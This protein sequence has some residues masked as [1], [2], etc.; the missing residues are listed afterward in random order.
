MTE[1][2]SR[3][4]SGRYCTRGWVYL[5]VLILTS[6]TMIYW[7]DLR[8]PGTKAYLYH[9]TIQATLPPHHMSHKTRTVIFNLTRKLKIFH[10]TVNSSREKRKNLPTFTNRATL[11]LTLEKK[12]DLTP[13]A[14]AMRAMH[15]ALH[16]PPTADERRQRQLVLWTSMLHPGHPQYEIYARPSMRVSIEALIDLY[17]RGYLDGTITTYIRHGVIIEKPTL[18]TIQPETLVDSPPVQCRSH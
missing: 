10:F 18:E 5:R 2:E 12:M 14:E 8:F 4:L 16:P 17:R 6:G 3:L 9:G 7:R 1:I 11:N 15:A 13:F